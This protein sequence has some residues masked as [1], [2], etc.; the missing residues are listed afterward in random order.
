MDWIIEQGDSLDILYQNIQCSSVEII[1]TLAP[2]STRIIS[3]VFRSIM[4]QPINLGSPS[5]SLR[6][7]L[8]GRIIQLAFKEAK[9]QFPET[10]FE[11]SVITLLFLRLVC[12][13]IINPLDYQ[14]TDCPP[15]ISIRQNLI[16]L[17]KFVQT[18]AGRCFLKECPE[19]FQSTH[20]KTL[21]SS[22][23]YVSDIFHNDFINF[24]FRTQLIASTCCDF[25]CPL[26]N[27][28]SRNHCNSALMLFLE[29]ILDNISCLKILSPKH[30]I[31]IKSSDHLIK[32]DKRE[33]LISTIHG[34]LLYYRL[35][36][37]ELSGVVD[38]LLNRKKIVTLRNSE[39]AIAF[40]GDGKYVRSWRFMK[41]KQV[42]VNGKHS[43]MV[44][45]ADNTLESEKAVADWFNVI[46][47]VQ[48]MF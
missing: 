37:F 2:I 34:L 46:D 17:A 5:F 19:D 1:E 3:G 14:I 40:Y 16:G 44:F 36:S 43:R 29:E 21:L 4:N 45:R 15:R 27:G 22:W 6:M 38:L 8:L 31:M 10:K 28:I 18:M 20:S 39:K 9:D 23:K 41:S 13:A 47:R 7:F 33:V 48:R 32:S 42:Y 11:A 26:P 24:C 12:P 30:G 25:R 35:N